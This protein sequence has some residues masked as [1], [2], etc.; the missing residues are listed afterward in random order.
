MCKKREKKKKERRGRNRI[1]LIG[2]VIGLAISSLYMLFRGDMVVSIIILAVSPVLVLFYYYFSIQL[3]ESARVKKIESIFP[4]FLQLMSSNL[5]AG[6]TIDR[7]MLLSVRKEFDPLDKEIQ[8][9][10]RDI[11]TG[12]EIEVALLDMSERI[13]SEKIKKVITLI[14][15]GIRAGGNLATL[16]E[17]PS[18]NMR[19]KLFVEKRASSSI[20]M[21]IIFIFVAVSVAAPALFALSSVLVETLINLLSGLPTVSAANMPFTLSSVSISVKFIKYFSIVFIIVSDI[22]ASLVL[23][24]VNKGEEKEG[25]RYMPFLLVISLTVF[26]LVRFLLLTVMGG[27]LS[28]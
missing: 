5:R 3:K 6:M 16:L 10:G 17:Q 11:A 19:E 22:L 21:Y 12:K 20:M 26:F 14:I 24:L 4:D 13:N 28:L 7:S 18:V 9:T 23:G 8:K 27:F 2:I 25:L 1:I 15:S